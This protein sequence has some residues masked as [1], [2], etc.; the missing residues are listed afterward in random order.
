MTTR[1]VFAARLALALPLLVFGLDGLLNF[2]PA[3]TY[4]EHGPR[5]AE[6]LSAIQGSGYLWQILKLAEVA[7]GLALVLG[8]FVPLALVVI[9]PVIV[10]IVGFHLTM[11][12]EGTW[13]AVYLVACTAFLAYAYRASFRSLLQSDAPE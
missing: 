4:P 12:R 11:E 10:N 3:D 7:V 13:L 8:K 9:A 5:A 1:L 6:F 2:L